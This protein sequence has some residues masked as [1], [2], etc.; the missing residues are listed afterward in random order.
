MI[1]SLPGGQVL[2]ALMQ[3]HLTIPEEGASNLCCKKKFSAGS[4]AASQVFVRNWHQLCHSSD[5]CHLSCVAHELRMGCLFP[6]GW[7]CEKFVCLRSS[8]ESQPLL[9]IYMLS[10]ASVHL[11]GR[12]SYGDRDCAA[13]GTYSTRT[14][15]APAVIA[16]FQSLTRAL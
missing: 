9:F 12:V 6:R 5:Q 8:M 13:H 2:W 16:C 3:T 11:G 4:S 14:R 10:V 15:R 1:Y 7:M